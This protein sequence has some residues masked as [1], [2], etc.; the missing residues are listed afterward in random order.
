LYLARN[1]LPL[2]YIWE[3]GVIYFASTPDVFPECLKEFK[4]EELEPYTVYHINQV[5]H[6]LEIIKQKISLLPEQE[7][8]ALVVCSSGIDST[9]AL[10]LL[11]KDGYECAIVHFKYKCRAEKRETYM[12]QKI[13]KHYG[14][15]FH[16]LDIPHIGGSRLTDNDAVFAEGIDACEFAYEWVPARNLIFVALATAL[17]EAKG[18]NY[19]ALGNNLEEAGAYPDNEPHMYTELNKALTYATAVNKRV[20][21]IQPVGN[22]MKHEIIKLAHELQIPLQYTWSCYEQGETPCGKCGSCTL[23]KI[24]H[25]RNGLIDNLGV[26]T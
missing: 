15:P 17:A 24:A 18:Y 6:T 16:F 23:R 26:I 11:L 19:L 12:I 2:F 7:R 14:I 9:V 5:G 4:V 1:Y 8:K 3:E 13:A 25:E 21:I 10:A 22:L 20:Q